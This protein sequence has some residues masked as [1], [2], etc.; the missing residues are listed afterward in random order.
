VQHSSHQP[1]AGPESPAPRRRRWLIAGIVTT[2]VVLAAVLVAGI[3]IGRSSGRSP[4]GH[5]GHHARPGSGTGATEQP[6]SGTSAPL[7]TFGNAALPT[8]AVRA[9]HGGTGTVYG[10]PVGYSHS[11]VGAV[12]ADINYEIALDSA[13]LLNPKKGDAFQQQ[14]FA[15]ADDRKA[16]GYSDKLLAKMRKYGHL[17]TKGK[18]KDH[19]K[20]LYDASYMRYGAFRVTKAKPKLS[21]D[22]P[23]SV[24]VQM[25]LPVVA[26]TVK[27][28]TRKGLKIEWGLRQ[29][30]V[31]W[32]HGDWR[33]TGNK[34]MPK[35][36]QPADTSTPI[37]SF[38]Q[39]AKILGKHKG[40]T[41]TNNAAEQ[42]VPG[43]KF[44][45][46]P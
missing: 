6:R 15:S 46:K 18:P 44:P 19:H 20:K 43:L 30:T 27:P 40:W 24:Q 7:T 8:A 17:D 45:V 32:V 39:R 13:Q 33:M 9:G 29:H 3:A 34:T 35:A 38:K 11:M 4:S 2:V 14:I 36:Q 28:G 10:M 5:A 12:E 1:P 37:T 16:M 41:L 23:K 26:G 42:P 21:S 31:S 22:E 25:W